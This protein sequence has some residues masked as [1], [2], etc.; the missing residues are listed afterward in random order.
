VVARNLLRDLA[1][2]FRGLFRSPGIGLL[3]LLSIGAGTG[4]NA[5]VFSLMDGMLFRAPEGVARPSGLATVFTSEFGGYPYGP[6][7]YPDFLTLQSKTPAFE[8]LAAIDD[9]QTIPVRLGSAL[10]TVRVAGVS[11]G[12]FSLIGVRA[13]RGRLLGSDDDRSSNPSAVIAYRFWQSAFERH[14]DAIGK[15]LS[16]NGRDY[17]IVGIASE[18]FAGLS[19]GRP[20]DVW[21]PLTSPGASDDRGE[22]RLGVIGRLRRRQS[23]R[24]A[25][26]Q[27]ASVAAQLA[28]EYP[29]TNRGMAERPDAPRTMSVLGY[30]RLD[31]NARSRTALIATI[32]FGASGVVLVCACA[33]AG[34]LLLSR[35]SS[36]ALEM[37]VRSALGAT[38]GRLLQQLLTESLVIAI[39]GGMIGL[40]LARWTAT[41]FPAFFSPEQAELIDPRINTQIFIFTL[42]MSAVASLLFGL[43]PAFLSTKSVV[44]AAL[45]S[46]PLGAAG[47]MGGVRLRATFVVV[48]IAL[49]IVLLVATMQLVRSFSRALSTESSQTA[50][51]IAVAIVRLPAMHFDAERF[52]RY[53]SDTMG[54]VRKIPGVE[55]AAW[56]S[57][58]P[59]ASNNWREFRIRHE[60][61]GI[62][63]YVELPIETISFDYFATMKIALVAGRNFDGRDGVR[64]PPVVIVNDIFARRYFGSPEAAIGQRVLDASDVDAEI[65]GVAESVW[66]RTLQP[67]PQPTLYSSSSQNFLSGANL[68]VRSS[69]APSGLLTRIN[70][71]LPVSDRGVEIRR[72]M[73][74][75]THLSEALALERLTTVLVA[76]CGALTLLLAIIGVYGVMAD[77]VMRRTR[78][79]G[80]RMALGARPMT[81]VRMI[82]GHS[83]SLAAIGVTV[84]VIFAAAASFAL[85]WLIEEVRP[86][87]LRTYAMIA[88]L[89]T[90]MVFLATVLPVRR[91][92]RVSPTVALRQE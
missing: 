39:C 49:S 46:D 21:I 47:A 29:K 1:Y 66:Y 78:E 10:Y 14:E 51:Q 26:T 16:I 52:R 17:T 12:Y 68:I 7:S 88:A 85:R 25:A 19:H 83:L 22:R 77:A 45:R 37:G 57:A 69:V 59:L 74:L 8:A 28:N 3:L 70:D 87:D 92:L 55:A 89:L 65:V 20:C 67:P 64:S 18:G 76:S 60:S 11:S 84:G 44:M 42:S 36:R 58:L 9:N 32:L 30:S 63:E 90:L 75:D 13:A 2:T 5:T 79:L 43:A 23:I 81:I 27:V 38:R 4:V 71:V 40:L 54:F 41:A 61:T 73:T 72:V 91:A 82:F 56:S 48:Q 35:A 6:S 24:A 34:G 50:H 62:T 80:V 33:S 53:Q 31:P 15:S 86:V